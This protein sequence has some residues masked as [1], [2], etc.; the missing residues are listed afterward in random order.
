ML[1]DQSEDIACAFDCEDEGAQ[2]ESLYR[3]VYGT[4]A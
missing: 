4:A 1:R 2:G 3:Y